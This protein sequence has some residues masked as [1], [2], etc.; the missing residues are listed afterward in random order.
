MPLL[1]PLAVTLALVVASAA[2]A[3]EWRVPPVTGEVAGDFTP[4]APPGLPKL[5]WTFRAEAGA[6]E[7]R[8]AHATIEGP[9]AQL[10]A[11]AQLDAAGD[12][13]WKL[14]QAEFD[15]AQWL[16]ASIA[17]F[18]RQ[19]MKFTVTG[20]AQFN[21]EGPMRAGAIAGGKGTITLRNGRIDAP[22]RKF[23]LEEV[24]LD[25]AFDDLAR[26]RT[27]AAQRLTWRGGQYGKLAL[28]PGRVVFA[29]EGSRVAV[30]EAS[31]AIFGGEI[32]F[33]P[34]ELSLQD[35]EVDVAADL[36]SIDMATLLP[37]M[38]TI[39]SEAHVMVLGWFRL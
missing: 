24:S 8:V 34:F 16:P 13:Q 21:G 20:A 9:G 2:A 10:R 26:G 39:V 38:P 4:L 12:G 29:L 37:F 5:H 1:R 31:V 35:P 33:D 17:L 27:A 14:T 25:L 19:A 22:A 28:G 32:V 7:Q 3:A 6:N 36:R 23:I 15:L 11:T 18:A 30:G